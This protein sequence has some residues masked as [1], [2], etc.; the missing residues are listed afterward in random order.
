MSKCCVKG[1]QNFRCS[2]FHIPQRHR[3]LMCYILILIQLCFITYS[4]FFLKLCYLLIHYNGLFRYY[5]QGI[6]VGAEAFRVI[7]CET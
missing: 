1:W 2:L 5:G 3:V 7:T 6:G 4:V